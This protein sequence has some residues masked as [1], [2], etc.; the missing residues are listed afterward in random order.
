MKKYGLLLTIIGTLGFSSCNSWLDVSPED[1]I[2]EEDLFA[3]GEGFRNALNG[4]YKAISNAELY[5]RN[6]TWGFVDA[7]GQCYDCERASQPA[8][9]M[10]YGAAEFDFNQTYSK[11]V[12]GKIWETAYNAVANCNNIIK[13]IE[14]V[15]A[16]M[17]MEKQRE[18]N[19]IWGE[20]LALRAFIQFDMLRLFAPSLENAKEGKYIPYVN[21]YPSLVAPPQTVTSCLEYM[22]ADLKEAREKVWEFDSLSSMK[23]RFGTFGAGDARFT[24]TRGYRLNYYAITGILARVYLYAGNKEAAYTEAKKIIDY[25][26]KK[27]DFNYTSSYYLENGNT[28]S[29]GD[30][31]SAFYKTLLVDW[32]NEV[33]G[34][35]SGQTLYFLS[36]L[37]IDEI[38]KGDFTI[39]TKEGNKN[40]KTDDYRLK[41][42]IKYLY[43]EYYSSYYF[44]PVKYADHKGLSYASISDKLIP[45][46]RMSELYY[47]AGEAICEKNLEEAIGYLVRVKQGRGLKSAAINNLKASITKPQIFIDEMMRDAR[48]EFLGEGQIFYMYK[49]M[50]KPIPGKNKIYPVEK[51]VLPLPDSQIKVN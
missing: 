29:Y 48:R 22:I 6:L 31:I 32:D 24:E 9:D 25:Q 21:E 15:S 47:I 18:K 26:D 7:M 10:K 2:K 41:Y 28:K 14:Q 49:R 11:D 5:G 42:W 3:T 39:E 20:A 45:I 23:Y 27:K 35:K 43:D 51:Y 36:V 19:M 30:L 16:D 38:Y 50:N 46:I 4:V 13:N 34:G 33:N 40:L 1:D 44:V 12:P 17:F 8:G 37:N